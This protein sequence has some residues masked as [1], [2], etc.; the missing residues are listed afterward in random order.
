M[1]T[2]RICNR[3]D[4]PILKETKLRSYPYYCPNCFE[5][6]YTIETH[7]EKLTLKHIGFFIVQIVLA[8]KEKIDQM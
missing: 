2:I 5:N 3:C 1:S 4:Y 8:I 6:Y 7:L